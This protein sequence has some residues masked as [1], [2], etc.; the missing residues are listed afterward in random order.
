VEQQATEDFQ[1]IAHL[2]LSSS[3]LPKGRDS[4][5][6]LEWW[7]IMQHYRVPTRLLDWSLSPLVAAYFAV[8]DHWDRDG[9]IWSISISTVERATLQ[10]DPGG[11]VRPDP[12]RVAYANN[13]L[14]PKT[15]VFRP[16]VASERSYPQQG[17]FTVCSNLTADHALTLVDK[18]DGAGTKMIIPARAKP[19]MLDELRSVN[20]S[21]A[22]LFPGLDGVGRT[23]A[24]RIRLSAKRFS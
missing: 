21:A 14:P 15:Y 8:S 10:K 17:L 3:Q 22:T 12:R 1:T 7:A 24:D 19:R 4:E 18:S 16:S 5:H 20:I 11:Y 23:I 6:L 2:Y 13:E 9:A